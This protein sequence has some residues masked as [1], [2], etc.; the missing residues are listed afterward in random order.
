MGAPLVR[1]Q[2][3][4]VARD[5]PNVAASSKATFR[6]EWMDDPWDGR[7]TRPG[8]WLLD[9]ESELRP[10]R[11]PPERLRARRAALA[12]AGAGGGPLVRAVVVA[13]RCRARP[14]RHEWA[15]YRGSGRARLA[16]GGSGRRA[17]AGDAG[18]ALQRHY[19]PLRGD[20]GDPERRAT[21][22]FRAGAEGAVRLRR[23]PA[24]GRGEEHRR[25]GP[26][27]RRGSRW[28][29][30]VAGERRHPDGNAHELATC[31]ARA[32]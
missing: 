30:C 25:A 10:G 1:A 3:R 22:A 6:L 24:V 18:S 16:G 26:G 29:V 8:D 2:R 31:T 23:R 14:R 20:G 19:G 17:D 15:R 11:R 21:G 32:V 9:L 12:R 5:L 28:P 13:R 27:R 7:A 4:E